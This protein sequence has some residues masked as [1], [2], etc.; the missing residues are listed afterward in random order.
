MV[1]NTPATL[2]AAYRAQNGQTVY[3]RTVLRDVFWEEDR[4][5]RFSKDGSD[6]AAHAEIFIPFSVDAQGKRYAAP[7]EWARAGLSGADGLFTFQAKD[8]LVKG[9]CEYRHGEGHPVSEL[10]EQYDG[11]TTITSVETNDFGS[12]D[13]RH[14]RIG[15]A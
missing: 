4:Q 10:L 11:A 13:M 12:A 5:A 8:F 2:Y 1:T 15:G 6:C 7:R 14:W 9:V 3:L